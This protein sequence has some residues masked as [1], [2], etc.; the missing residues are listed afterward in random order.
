MSLY[1]TAEK[2]AWNNKIQLIF[3]SKLLFIIIILYYIYYI[4][5]YYIAYIIILLL[6]LLYLYFFL[7]RS[8]NN[9]RAMSLP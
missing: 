1:S 3:A 4:I 6:F 2:F 9:I 7:D 5:Y 8:L